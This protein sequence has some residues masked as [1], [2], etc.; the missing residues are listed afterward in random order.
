MKRKLY[1][2]TSVIGGY[3]DEEFK[4]ETRK[5]WKLA[6]ENQYEFNTSVVTLEEITG[7]PDAVQKLFR[8][9]FNMT[10]LFQDSKESDDLALAYIQHD[11][12]HENYF[13]DAQHV[14]ICT[15]AGIACLVSWNFKHLANL[16]RETAF[17][18]GHI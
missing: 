15:L 13:D 18:E 14:A 17:N 7:A 11:V 6:G 5:L 12:V 3:F 2:D 16:K 9:T 4:T 10:S 1:L 8:K